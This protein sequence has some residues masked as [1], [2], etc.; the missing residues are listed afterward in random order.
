MM[1]ISDD[2]RFIMWHL[3]IIAMLLV[4][5][6]LRERNKELLT[7]SPAAGQMHPIYGSDDSILNNPAANTYASQSVIGNV[8]TPSLSKRRGGG[9]AL[10]SSRL[11]PMYVGVLLF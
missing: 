2:Y 11:Y 5:V 7:E 1:D 9:E 3:L 8:T 6:V 4:Y 10:Y